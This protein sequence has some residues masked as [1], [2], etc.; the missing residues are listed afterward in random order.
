MATIDRHSHSPRV[1]ND[2]R[3]R[4]N[5]DGSLR[6]RLAIVSA[7]GAR[8]SSNRGAS[9]DRYRALNL[10]R[11]NLDERIAGRF[12]RD[13]ES[14]RSIARKSVHVRN[15][16]IARLDHVTRKRASRTEHNDETSGT[17]AASISLVT[18]TVSHG[19]RRARYYG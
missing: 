7:A 16:R 4:Q 3:G 8:H 17:I 15:E 2:G 9:F 10:G 6:T 18:L 5:P 1:V 19:Q 14:R 12:S 11:E 13:R